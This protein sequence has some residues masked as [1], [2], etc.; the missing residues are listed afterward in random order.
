M[1]ASRRRRRG[2]CDIAPIHLLDPETESYNAPFLTPE[3]TLVEGWRRMQGLVFRIGDARFEGRSVGEAVAA[4]LTDPACQM[5]NRNA[6]AGT[7]ILLDRL[8]G[9][10]R[11]AGYWNQPKS[12]NAVAAA[13]AQS[14]ADWGLA[15]L[16]VARAYGSAF[17]RFGE[18]HYDFAIARA[19]L[20]LNPCGPSS[21][22]CGA[23]TFCAAC[24][25]SASP[26]PPTWRARAFADGSTR[27]G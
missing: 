9:R 2:E 24:A 25:A 17:C 13:I 10:A 3:L 19:R 6:G 27:R 8:I 4:A 7:R 15:I 16:P 1:G 26:L 14:R 21:K 5:V 22:R 11:P 23:M 20:A 12:H 18:E